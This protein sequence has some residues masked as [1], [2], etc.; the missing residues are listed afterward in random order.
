MK[1][2]SRLLKYLNLPLS[3]SEAEQLGKL[4]ETTPWITGHMVARVC[5]RVGLKVCLR[6]PDVI[7]AQL[8]AWSQSESASNP[9]STNVENSSEQPALEV[10]L[11]PNAAEVCDQATNHSRP[12][13]EV[14]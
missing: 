8:R 11:T 13:N 10:P 3:T 1:A 2:P 12:A 4:I 6:R 5:L 14:V 9:T 7:Q